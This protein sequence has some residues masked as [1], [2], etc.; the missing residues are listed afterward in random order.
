MIF[1]KSF[2]LAL[3]YSNRWYITLP[4]SLVLIYYPPEQTKS[5]YTEDSHSPFPSSLTGDGGCDITGRILKYKTIEHD[6]NFSCQ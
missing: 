1:E 4:C 6:V 2:I 5:L 3:S